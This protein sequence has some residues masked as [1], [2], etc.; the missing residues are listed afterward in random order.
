MSSPSQCS[1]SDA[2]PAAIP[3]AD[4]EEAELPAASPEEADE[5]L[6][7]AELLSTSDNLQPTSL[8]SPARAASEAALD[9]L[10]VR[11]LALA[12]ALAACHHLH[13]CAA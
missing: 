5:D 6:E 3:Q 8:P 2:L 12:L 9:K 10:L 7:D 1:A 11:A 4:E 13:T